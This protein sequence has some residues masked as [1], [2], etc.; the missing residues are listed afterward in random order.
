MPPP[1]WDYSTIDLKE[2]EEYRMHRNPL[3]VTLHPK[4]M[5][6]WARFPKDYKSSSDLPSK[7]KQRDLL[8]SGDLVRVSVEGGWKT[9]SKLRLI[10]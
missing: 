10:P 8:P 9:R 5:Q 7:S 4:K 1:L 2:G 3:S 6:R